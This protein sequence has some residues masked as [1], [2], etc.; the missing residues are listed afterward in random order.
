M[1]KLKDVEAALKRMIEL[2]RI[3]TFDDWAGTLEKIKVDF[4]KDQKYQSSKLLS[5]YGGMGSLN[6][7]VFYKNGQPQIAENN[8]FDALRTHIYEL[9]KALA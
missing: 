6:D 4:D 2:L 8:E 5:L 9:C 1:K 7:I 3:G